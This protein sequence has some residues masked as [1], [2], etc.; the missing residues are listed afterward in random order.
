MSQVSD[1]LPRRHAS[2]ETMPCHSVCLPSSLLT[3]SSPTFCFM[4]AEA[5][6]FY[7]KLRSRFSYFTFQ[8][9]PTAARLNA[10]GIQAI[11]KHDVIRDH[12][13]AL[14]AFVEYKLRHS[15]GAKREVTL[16]SRDLRRSLSRG[17]F[18]ADV[19]R[20]Y[21]RTSTFLMKRG[22]SLGV[23]RGSSATT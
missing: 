2:K 23:N 5:R 18:E 6:P 15:I 11:Q 14:Q 13:H 21:T 20:V 12:C 10:L 9:H 17:A 4:T 19:L 8:T 1:P 3:V 16:C 22:A 7:V